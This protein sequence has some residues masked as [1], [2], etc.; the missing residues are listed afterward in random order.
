MNVITFFEE[1]VQIWK[2]NPEENIDPKCGE[3]W[4]FGAPLGIA[5]MNGF[6]TKADDKCCVHLFITYYKTSSS[7]SKNTTTGLINR[8]WCDHMF[9]L[10]AVKHSDISLNLY[11]EQPYHPIEESIWETILKPLQN[12]LGCGNELELCELDY[13][14]EIARWEMEVVKKYE[15]SNYAGWKINGTFRQYN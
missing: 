3:C 11:N 10:Y 12:C 7:Y 15:D 6:K 9:T 5:E 1:L 8:S 2:G 14:F 4:V 13:D